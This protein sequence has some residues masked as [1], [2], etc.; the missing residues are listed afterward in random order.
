[1][2]TAIKFE[3]FKGKMRFWQIIEQRSIH[4]CQ[5][6]LHIIRNIELFVTYKGIKS[7]RYITTGEDR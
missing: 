4:Y 7:G 5:Y 6:V 1:M 3:Y 2:F